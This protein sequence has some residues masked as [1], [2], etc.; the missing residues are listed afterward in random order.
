MIALRLNNEAN[1]NGYPTTSWLNDGMTNPQASP[2]KWFGKAPIG[3]TWRIHSVT[4]DLETI[5]VSQ[6]AGV[7]DEKMATLNLD[8]SLWHQHKHKHPYGQGYRSIHHCRLYYNKSNNMPLRLRDLTGDET[9]GLQVAVSNEDV[10][11]MMDTPFGD[12]DWPA[13]RGSPTKYF[14]GLIVSPYLYFSVTHGSGQGMSNYTA[15]LLTWVKCYIEYDL[16]K[17]SLWN[18]TYYGLSESKKL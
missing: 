10:T 18:E 9:T 3:K 6:L 14:K 16:V 7:D 1:P 17:K 15:G 4:F 5:H 13:W 11:G 2:I 8:F 12:S